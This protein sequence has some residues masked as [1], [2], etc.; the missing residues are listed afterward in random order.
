[1]KI[2]GQFSNIGTITIGLR[3]IG[4]LVLLGTA[5]CAS[6]GQEKREPPTVATTTQ[7]PAEQTGSRRGGRACATTEK[8]SL[9]VVQRRHLRF[10]FSFHA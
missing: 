1:M 7:A 3:S 9:P 5:V 2:P 4:I 10:N 6:G 8:S